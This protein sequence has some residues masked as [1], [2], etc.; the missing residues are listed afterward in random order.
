M[1]CSSKRWVPQK[2]SSVLFERSWL[3]RRPLWRNVPEQSVGRRGANGLS[4][5]V[6]TGPQARLSP[7]ALLRNRL[8]DRRQRRGVIEFEIAA[9]VPQTQFFPELI[10]IRRDRLLSP[11]I[12]QTREHIDADGL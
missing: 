11:F 5:A 10:E 12:V 6:G 3:R 8:A 7:A 9:H 4:H 2:K 1:Q